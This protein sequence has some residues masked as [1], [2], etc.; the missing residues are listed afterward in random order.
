MNVYIQKLHNL[1]KFSSLMHTRNILATTVAITTPI[2]QDW[3]RDREGDWHTH[4]HT[5]RDR[6]KDRAGETE[7]AYKFKEYHI[8]LIAITVYT[9][10]FYSCLI[11]KGR[12]TSAW[13]LKINCTNPS[14]MKYKILENYYIYIAEPCRGCTSCTSLWVWVTLLNQLSSINTIQI[15]SAFMIDGNPANVHV[16]NNIWP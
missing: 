12:Y 14:S 9:S 3:E 13:T 6:G 2:G 1:Q 11:P 5:Q 4:K 7:R 8:T 16:C 10:N 15:L